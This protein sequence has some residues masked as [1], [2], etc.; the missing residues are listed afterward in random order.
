V[1]C[2]DDRR[3]EL[4]TARGLEVSRLD[5]SMVSDCVTGPPW[6]EPLIGQ[7]VLGELDLM[8]DCARNTLGPRPESPNLPLLKLKWAE[9]CC[10]YLERRTE[11][12]DWD[13]GGRRRWLCRFVWR[14]TPS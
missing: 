1:A 2:A 8:L 5:R 6:C 7:L 3:E 4:P 14:P 9:R 11:G 12:E 10:G 13:G